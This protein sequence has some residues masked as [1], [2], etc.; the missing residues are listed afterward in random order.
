M[1]K[2]IYAVL[3]L[4]AAM[5]FSSIASAQDAGDVPQIE[6]GIYEI[7]KFGNIMLD[8]SA[9]SMQEL[10]YET[11]DLILVKIGEREMEMPIG[12]E[13]TDADSGEPICRYK[14]SADAAVNPVVLAVNSGN[15]A[16]VMGVAD[17]SA[18]ITIS[19]VEKQGYA[20]EYALHALG[21]TRTNNREDYAALSDEEYANF[22]AVE[23]TGM[24]T[25]TLYRSSSP[26]NPA[27][28]RNEEADEA[29]LNA[30]IK[31]IVN[32]ADSEEEMKS[33]ADYILTNYS[34]CDI[35]PLNM[36]LDLQ[37]DEFREKLAEGYRFIAAHEGPYLIHCKEG[38][39]RTGFV[40][41]VLECLMG[42]DA[43]EIEQ[44][45]ML[46]YYNYYGIGPDAEQYSTFVNAEIRNSLMKSFGIASLEGEDLRA[47][48][49]EYLLGIGMTEEEITALKENLAGDYGGLVS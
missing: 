15:L 37:S 47:C 38:K 3:V 14:I 33:Y 39:D 10:G 49:E 8:I 12:L 28:N 32:T 41:A 13:Y 46:T 19:M 45:Y 9:E 17:D 7:T 20:E 48:A 21:S 2:N 23:T 27:L 34:K 30:L 36:G 43:G 40:C 24:G 4:A 26:I 22:R 35:L 16:A 1:K 25:G 6:A 5:L 31:T 44:D 29:L 18:G 42:A 11:A